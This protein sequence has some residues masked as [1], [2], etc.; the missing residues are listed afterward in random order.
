MTSSDLFVE[1]LTCQQHLTHAEQALVDSGVSAAPLRALMMSL[2]GA[3]Q[4][5]SPL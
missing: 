3:G 2:F 1:G 4:R 5:G